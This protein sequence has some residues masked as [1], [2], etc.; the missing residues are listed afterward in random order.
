MS[1]WL[2]VRHVRACTLTAALV[3]VALIPLGDIYLPLP[4]LFAG[5][6][7]SVPLSF[8]LPLTV[9]IVLEWSLTAGEPAIESVSARRLPMLDAVYALSVAALTFVLCALTALVGG[10]DLA[11]AAGRNV[12]GYVGLTLISRRIVGPHVAAVIPVVWVIITSLFGAGVGG[13]PRR[14]AWP[15]AQP[16]NGLSW[17]IAV[18]LL[19]LGT[20]LFHVRTS[21]VPG[22]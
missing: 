10:A 4:D 13:Q 9:P 20:A 7:L 22:E 5:S 16:E 2:R 15:L 1:L 11:L 6:G 14:W 3:A 8:M 18:S 17:G 19:I 21:R 12:L